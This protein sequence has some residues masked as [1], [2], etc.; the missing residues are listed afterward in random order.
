MGFFLGTRLPFSSYHRYLSDISQQWSMESRTYWYD[1]LTRECGFDFQFS[2]SRSIRLR[3]LGGYQPS[4]STSL[5]GRDLSTIVPGQR[6]TAYGRNQW[7]AQI[8]KEDSQDR[9]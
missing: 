5:L 8:V 6:D 2:I 7:F 9:L 1:G 4:C 3:E